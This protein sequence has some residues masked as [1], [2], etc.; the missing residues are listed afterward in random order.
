MERGG[1]G[2]QNRGFIGRGEAV[3]GCGCATGA[4]GAAEWPLR[5]LAVAVMGEGETEA[6]ALQLEEEEGARGR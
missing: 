2:G 6:V 5:P 4:G 3:G 1:I